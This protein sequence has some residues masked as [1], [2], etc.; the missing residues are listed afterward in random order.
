MGENGKEIKNAIGRNANKIHTQ[1]TCMKPSRIQ[2]LN[3]RRKK[4]DDPVL[5]LLTNAYN[6]VVRS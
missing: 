4:V 6:S 1:N 5:Q 2:E 3:R